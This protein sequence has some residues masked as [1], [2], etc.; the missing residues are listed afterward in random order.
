MYLMNDGSVYVDTKYANE[1]VNMCRELCEDVDRMDNA[2]T[3]VTEIHL[4]E[5]D[6]YIDDDL[7]SICEYFSERGVVIN[8]EFE[9]WGDYDGKIVIEN[10]CVKSY[11]DEEYGANEALKG[12]S[13]GLE[14]KEKLLNELKNFKGKDSIELMTKLINETIT[15]D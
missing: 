4:S 14:L 10:N 15:A 9:Y 1:L 7:D 13:I 3:G 2:V 11:D 8:G 5:C 12:N 6:G